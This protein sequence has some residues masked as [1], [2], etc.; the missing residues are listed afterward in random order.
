MWVIAALHNGD[1]STNLG[2]QSVNTV[3]DGGL[4]RSTSELLELALPLGLEGVSFDDFNG[5][6]ECESG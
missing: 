5:L 2:L 1:F 3:D 6:F 4:C